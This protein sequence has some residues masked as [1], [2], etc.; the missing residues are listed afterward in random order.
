[1]Q[2]N[3]LQNEYCIYMHRNKV[4]NKLYIGQTNNPKKRWYPSNYAHNQYFYAAIQ[5]YGW[6]N[7]EH[8]ILLEH[9][10]LE[11]ANQKEVEFIALYNT[12]NRTYG[13]NIALGGNN[14]TLSLE[15]RQKMSINHRDVKGKNN[16]FYGK[17][18]TGEKHPF[19]GKHHTEHSKEKISIN[20][21]GKG[22]R[23]VLC[24][25][26]QEQFL[27]IAEAATWCGLKS[28]AHIGACCRGERKSAGKHPV[29]KESLHWQYVD[30]G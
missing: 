15:T 21:K 6:D 20:R 25:N 29:T 26:T 17:H 8:I 2:K 30:I 5:K 4:N 3:L 28:G 18:F 12:T 11:E 9:L 1:M 27:T 10:T 22:G 13:Y 7:F 16:Y 14:K 24:I 23:M 19:Y